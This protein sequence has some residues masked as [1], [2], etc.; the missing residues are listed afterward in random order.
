MKKALLLIM[1]SIG[2]ISQ[3]CKEISLDPWEKDTKK[4]DS[5]SSNFSSL[6]GTK[7]KL[8]SIEKAILTGGFSTINIPTNEYYTINFNTH[9]EISGQADCNAYGGVV[10]HNSALGT[11]SINISA[12]L[13]TKIGCGSEGRDQE[14]ITG[15]NT[16]FHFVRNENELQFIYNFEVPNSGN[17]GN[18]LIFEKYTDPHDDSK[19]TYTVKM[20]DSKKY[21][22]YAFI[23]AE[24]EE[25]LTD[26]KNCNLT[27]NYKNNVW[28]A[29]L[30]ADCNYGYAD[31]SFSNEYQ[32]IKFDNIVTSKIACQNQNTANRFVDFLRNTARFEYSD[33]G[34]TLTIWSSLPSFAMSKMVLKIQSDE[35]NPEDIIQ[36][37]DT[38][39]SGVPEGTIYS[40]N[41]QNY[42]T[43]DEKNVQFSYTYTGD[44]KDLVISAYSNFEYKL[45]DPP[46]IIIDIVP[47]GTPAMNAVTY[48]GDITV[49][50]DELR[51]RLNIGNPGTY[52][53]GVVLRYRGVELGKVSVKI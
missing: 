42:R 46:L 19:L 10:S 37:M 32:D 14:F 15:L 36:I 41:I 11:N 44:V 18:S 38:P 48:K 26:S 5:T 30:L 20:L 31:V 25:I 7:W 40:F 51:K 29:D 47:T 49:S 45:S 8:K 24:S 13:I 27:I 6:I 9:S 1:I 3:S 16:A 28:K 21:T 2:I 34:N 52:S 17:R 35:Q 12:G 53:M 39:S 43:D 23:N 4:Q 33:Y 50:L 22:L